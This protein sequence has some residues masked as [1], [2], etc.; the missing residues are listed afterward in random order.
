MQTDDT[1]QGATSF[2]SEWANAKRTFGR[3]DQSSALSQA[4]SSP[5]AKSM[6]GMGVPDCMQQPA[7]L[8]SP[9]EIRDRACAAHICKAHN[10]WDRARR[11]FSGVMMQSPQHE[12]TKGCKFER[13]LAEDITKGNAIDAQICQL[14]Q[15]FL[16][17]ER[18][19]GEDVT[20]AA[21]LTTDIKEIIKGG[22]RLVAAMKPWFK[23]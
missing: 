12:N 7:A 8:P 6:A 2:D 17:G 10:A 13:N 21:T 15:K 18:F 20:S 11:E 19:T 23:L 9:E 5:S 4:S 3:S 1:E 16:R 22:G 14:E